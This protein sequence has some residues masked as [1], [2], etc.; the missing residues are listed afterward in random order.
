VRII[1]L[2]QRHRRYGV[3][4]IHLKLL[5]AARE[6]INYKR[7]ERLYRFEKLHIR[8]IRPVTVTPEHTIGGD[9]QIRILES[10]GEVLA[11][12]KTGRT[13]VAPQI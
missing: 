9:H 4:M 13:E 6:P 12:T 3:G 1:A 2:A 7:V 8:R 11:G 5:Q 10:I